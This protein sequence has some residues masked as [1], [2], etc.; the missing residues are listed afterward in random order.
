MEWSEE[1]KEPEPGHRHISHLWA[2][3]PGH[4]IHP[5]HTPELA[6][7]C[8]QTLN[9]RLRHG[10][11]HTGW[12]R[13][14][15]INFYARLQD[16]EE[17]Y[18][19]L[20]KLFSKSTY[21]NLFDAHPPFQIDGNFGALS[22][23]AEMLIQSRMSTLEGSAK[24]LNSFDITLLPALPKAWRKGSIKG[25]RTRGACVVDME[26]DEGAIVAASLIAEKGGTFNIR[27]GDK[28]ETV[29]LQPGNSWT[30]DGMD[31]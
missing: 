27:Y 17:A 2:L 29:R 7:A 10:G 30:N 16:S 25:L 23:V 24:D 31:S 28:V 1:Y 15:M 14:W 6:E 11:G 26:W 4:R 22:G 18:G 13:S 12:S 9:Q 5:Q 20:Q 8:N 3:Y 19:H 21:P